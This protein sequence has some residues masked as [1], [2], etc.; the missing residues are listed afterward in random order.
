[1]M[2][3]FRQLLTGRDIAES[4]HSDGLLL[5]ILLHELSTPVTQLRFGLLRIEREYCGDDKSFRIQLKSLLSAVEQISGIIA[6]CGESVSPRSSRHDRELLNLNSICEHAL[7]TVKRTVA[8]PFTTRRVYSSGLMIDGSSPDLIRA[9]INILKNAI[10]A[11]TLIE[12]IVISIETE[13][14]FDNGSPQAIVRII[15]NGCGIQPELLSSLG[16][17]EAVTTKPGSGRGFGVHIA[18][19]IVHDHGGKMEIR[20]P[21]GSGRGTC[22][23]ISLPLRRENYY[24]R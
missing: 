20:S 22:V 1:M 10:E 19:T 17:S 13:L 8:Q 23:E 12:K 11:G 24:D 5:G 21:V 15:D 4:R 2:K 18:S 9:V 16:T 6:S 7:L 14:Q 3:I